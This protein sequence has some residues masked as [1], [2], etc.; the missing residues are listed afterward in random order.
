MNSAQTIEAQIAELIDGKAG[1]AAGAL[2]GS[3][4]EVASS[5]DVQLAALVG[6]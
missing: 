1:L 4:E 3:G 6:S 2:D 5:A